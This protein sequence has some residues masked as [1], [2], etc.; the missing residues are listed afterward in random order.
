MLPGSGQLIGALVQGVSNRFNRDQ[1][2]DADRLGVR[3][4]AAAGYDPHGML[5]VLDQLQKEAPVGAMAQFFSSHPPYPE[6]REIVSQEIA[7]LP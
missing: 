7:A 5:T 4:A 1:E 2:R 3:Y 6:R